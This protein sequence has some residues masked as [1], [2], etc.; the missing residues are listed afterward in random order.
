MSRGVC[1]NLSHGGVLF[2]ITK[3]KY[4]SNFN[5]TCIKIWNLSVTQL[6][7]EKKKKK[8]A[9]SPLLSSPPLLQDKKSGSRRVTTRRM[10]AEGSVG[11]S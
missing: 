6:T 9:S 1:E 8:L 3:C 2:P 5:F 7:E 4:G 11:I 10:G